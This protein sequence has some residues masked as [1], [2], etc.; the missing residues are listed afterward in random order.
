MKH[1]QPIILLIDGQCHLCHWITKFVMKHD[2][3]MMFQFATLQSEAGKALL[4]E[5][6]LPPDDLDTFVMVAGNHFYTKSDAAFRVFR[7]LHGLWPLLYIGLI[8]PP[9]IRNAVYDRIAAG[10]YRWFG[11]RDD[12]LLPTPDLLNRF[13]H[14]AEEARKR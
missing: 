8:I 5:G 3:A 2:Q 10:R 9:L 14:T 11:K 4:Q 1:E 12:C 7:K 13:I 6:G